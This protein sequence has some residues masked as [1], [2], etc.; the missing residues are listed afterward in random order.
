MRNPSPEAC[1]SFSLP[2]TYAML[3]LVSVI[4]GGTFVAGRIFGWR[5]AAASYCGTQVFTGQY[6]ACHLSA[7]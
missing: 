2:R 5:N 3:G 6:H 1:S 7:H 4:W